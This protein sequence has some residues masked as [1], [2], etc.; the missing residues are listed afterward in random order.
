[1][2]NGSK[3]YLANRKLGEIF[4]SGKPSI[5]E[6]I[7]DG[8]ACWAY[9]EEIVLNMRAAGVSY[10]GVIVKETGDRFLTPIANLFDPEKMKIKHFDRGSLQRHLPLQYFSRRPGKLPRRKR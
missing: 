10:M 1:L 2:P 8:V 6:A 4:R 5:A 3:V 7:R 9:D